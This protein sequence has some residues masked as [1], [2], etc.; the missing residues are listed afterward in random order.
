MQFLEASQIDEWRVQHDAL[1]VEPAPRSTSVIMTRAYG[2]AAEPRGQEAEVAA[3]A[4]QELG[5]WDECLLVV[6][7][8]GIWPSSEDWPK[9]YAERGAHGERRSLDVAPGHLFAR[10]EEPV[11]LR[12]LQIVL[13]N[14]WDAE[15]LPASGRRFNGRQLVVSHDELVWVTEVQ[16]RADAASAV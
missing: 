4:I 12:F 5:N 13:E 8:W 9:Y 16:D 7:S 1:L 6:K 10:S 14:A 2:D 15:A 11:F 3:A